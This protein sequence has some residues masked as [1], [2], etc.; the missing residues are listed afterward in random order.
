MLVSQM[1]VRPL[2]ELFVTSK[3]LYHLQNL[4]ILLL[5]R[6]TTCLAIIKQLLENVFGILQVILMFYRQ[7]LFR[8]HFL[9]KAVDNEF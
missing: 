6:I 5:G 8:V 2:R 9:E 7:K 3:T 4:T 1:N